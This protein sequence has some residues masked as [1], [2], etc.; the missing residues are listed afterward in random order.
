MYGTTFHLRLHV[1]FHGNEY[2]VVHRKVFAGFRNFGDLEVVLPQEMMGV[3]VARIVGPPHIDFV[4]TW[5]GF[6][7]HCGW[8]HL[9]VLLELLLLALAGFP[10]ILCQCIDLLV[11]DVDAGLQQGDH[12]RHCDLRA[13]LQLLQD[14]ALGHLQKL[15]GQFPG[16][17]PRARLRDAHG[18]QDPLWHLLLLLTK[19]A[20][21]LHNLVPVLLLRH[22]PPLG[23][24]ALV[25]AGELCLALQ[26]LPLRKLALL[27]LELVVLL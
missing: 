27:R 19:P 16:T 20:H 9:A 26:K 7:V 13:V 18:A 5:S 6:S 8:R 12:G 10:N 4:Q 23:K 2:W 1:L 25:N 14:D 21:R 15:L 22:L 3:F 17:P 24:A 11:P